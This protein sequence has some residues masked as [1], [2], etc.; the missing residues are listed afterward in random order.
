MTQTYNVAVVGA[1]G[2]VGKTMLD[3]LQ[4]RQFPVA[5]I[6]PLA[7][8]RSAGDTIDFNKQEV[9][10]GNLAEFD[11][12]QADIALFSAGGSVSAEYAPVA[13]DAG[14]VV[15]DNTSHFRMED[16]IPLVVPEVPESTVRRR[17]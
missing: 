3:I 14:C 16:D 11:F 7:S 1:T 5:Q 12:S 6:F 15:V 2:A 13:A 9:T 10:V 4:E 8:E 17:L